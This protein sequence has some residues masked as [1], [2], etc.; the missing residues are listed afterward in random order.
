MTKKGVCVRRKCGQASAEINR[1]NYDR[2]LEM[3]VRK[4]K[5]I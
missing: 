1:I 5:T 3:L 2:E 4:E